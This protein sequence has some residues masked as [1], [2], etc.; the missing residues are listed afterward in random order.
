[1]SFNHLKTLVARNEKIAMLTCYDASFAKLSEAAGVDALL[2]GDS[3]G[4]VLQG[5][6]NTLG[7][8]IDDMVYHTRAVAAGSKTCCIIAD[9]P[10]GDVGLDRQDVHAATIGTARRPGNRETSAGLRRAGREA[11][12]RTGAAVSFKG[13]AM[14]KGPARAGPFRFGARPKDQFFD[15]STSALAL[16]HGIMSRSF[17]PTSSI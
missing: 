7:V 14:K 3:L 2:V 8:S 17:S 13:R 12:T 10:V 4:M 16:I 6:E 11:E 5:A 9:M 1:M 15:L